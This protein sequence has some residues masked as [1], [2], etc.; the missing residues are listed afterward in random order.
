MKNKPK[1]NQFFYWKS[2][3][4][5]KSETKKGLWTT[6]EGLLTLCSWHPPTSNPPARN[7]RIRPPPL[8]ILSQTFRQRQIAPPVRPPVRVNLE[9]P[10]S[11]LFPSVSRLIIPTCRRHFP[12]PCSCFQK[13]EG[14]L[15]APPCFLRNPSPLF[16]EKFAQVFRHEGKELPSH[17]WVRHYWFPSLRPSPLFLWANTAFLSPFP[18]NRW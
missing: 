10:P 17:E 1:C 7:R 8:T 9:T 6:K 14:E 11:P 15:G 4:I 16:G 5:G 13:M 12:F 2:T 3:Q 18:K